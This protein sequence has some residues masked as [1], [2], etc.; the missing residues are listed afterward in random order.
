MLRVEYFLFSLQQ[1]WGPCLTYQRIF[2]LDH[3]T[4][5]WL[6][7][8]FHLQY[9][10]A[11]S[12]PTVWLDTLICSCKV[13]NYHLWVLSPEDIQINTGPPSILPTTGGPAPPLIQTN[14]REQ[15]WNSHPP[16]IPPEN[17]VPRLGEVAELWTSAID[18]RDK[19]VLCTLALLEQQICFHSPFPRLTVQD[20]RRPVHLLLE[21]VT[22]VGLAR[23][24]ILQGSG[25]KGAGK[26]KMF[27][28]WVTC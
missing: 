23:W 2:P 20:P 10:Q 16:L 21:A 12:Q 13:I 7:R 19:F 5:W 27:L 24:I 14:L 26:S 15:T 9:M 17:V 6:W 22:S 4:A 18:R 28:Y 11:I 1:L 3:L 25:N 8:M